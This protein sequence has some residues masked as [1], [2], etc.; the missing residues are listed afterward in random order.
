MC[1]ALSE[2]RRTFPRFLDRMNRMLGGMD[3]MFFR[4]S[5]FCLFLWH[6]VHS[7]EDLFTTGA[8]KNNNATPSST[9]NAG[10]VSAG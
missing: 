8:I 9:S 7:V 3:R 6:S 2:V 10:T 1:D 5:E 4:D